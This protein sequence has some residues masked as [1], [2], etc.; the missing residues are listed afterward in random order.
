M[1]IS[2]FAAALTAC[3]SL[4]PISMSAKVYGDTVNIPERAIVLSGEPGEASRDNI[5]I[6]YSR[7]GMAFDDPSAPRFLFLDRQGKVALGI[8]GYV[9]GIAMYDV[10]GAIDDDGFTTYEIPTPFDPAR[11]QRFGA[12]ASQS[13]IFLKLVAR[14]SRLGKIIVYIQTGFKTDYGMKLKQAYVSVGH[15]TAGLARST[16][17]DG[18]AQAPVI[19]P[20]GPSGEISAKNMLFRY[21]TSSYKGFSAAASIEIPDA[22][23]TLAPATQTINQRFPDIPVY[24]QYAWSGDS[25]VRLSGIFRQLSYRDL[26]KGEN[27]FA[28]GWGVHLSSVGHISGELGYFGHFAYG[29]G[30]ARYIKDLS[31]FGYDLVPSSE[32]GEIKA[33]GM[34]AWTAGLSYNFTKRFF[35]TANVSQARVYDCSAMARDSYRYGQYATINAFYNITGDFQ[36]GA[37]FITGRRVDL[38]GVKGH[39]NRFEA[40]MQYSF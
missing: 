8:G 2:T 9:E 6:L 12:D 11:R 23:Y 36:I 13:T 17:A 22:D 29:K 38:D 7:E 34:M 5:A 20:Q 37:E 19:D 35:V 24:V 1:K 33:P 39:A 18:E 25:H 40:M 28:T 30:I 4:L 32:T 21:T 26:V 14:D 15:L 16:F 31:G 10:D 27:H 3:A